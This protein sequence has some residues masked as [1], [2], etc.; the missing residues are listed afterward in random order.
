MF[1]LKS[2][3]QNL[4]KN[5][6]KTKISSDLLENLYSSQFKNAED[7]LGI[8]IL[9]FDIWNLHLGK[10]ASL[11]KLHQIYLKIYTQGILK[12]LNTNLA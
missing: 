9:R 8:D 7:E 2:L 5:G 4:G 1:G 10:L 6:A 3:N 11:L 12:V